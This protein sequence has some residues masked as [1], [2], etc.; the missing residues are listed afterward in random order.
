M[1]ECDY[2]IRKH[3]N[4]CYG[5]DSNKLCLYYK[6]DPRGKWE[7]KNVGMRISLGNPIPDVGETTEITCN[8]I[9]K[10][11]KIYKINYVYWNTEGKGLQGIVLGITCG[12]WTEEGGIIPQKPDLKVIKGG[13]SADMK[14]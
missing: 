8:G 4:K 9:D 13:V 10:T 2:C 5:K 11:I 1:E 3:N 6:K 14:T 12:Y 7:I